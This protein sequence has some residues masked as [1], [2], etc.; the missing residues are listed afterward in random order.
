M[1][2]VIFPGNFHPVGTQRAADVM[3]DRVLT[4]SGGDTRPHPGSGGVWLIVGS[5]GGFG[6][7][8]RL[9]LGGLEGAHT[10]GLSLD[11]QPNPESNNKI[12]KLGSPG[13]HRNRAVERRLTRHGLIARSLDGDAFAPG[14]RDRVVEEIRDHFPAKLSGIVWSLAAPRATDPRT[15][16][17]VA[18][19]LKPLGK[20]A[21]IKTLR[22]PDAKKGEPA[23]VEEIELPP[24]SPEEA[25]S[26]IYVMG[27]GIVAQW[28]EHLIEADVLAEGC[29][30]LTISYRGNPMN[31]PIY[32]DG[33]IGLAKADLEL[34]TKAL[35]ARLGHEVG[36]GAFA[37]EGPAVVTEASGGIP[38]VPFYLAT[39][40]DVMGERHED[41]IDSM[42]R[43]VNEHLGPAGPKPDEEGLI[44]MDDRELGDEV[45]EAIAARFGSAKPGDA[46]DDAAFQRFMAEYA[47]TR[48]FEVPGVDYGAEFDTDEVT[49]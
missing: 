14:M 37:V 19:A 21:T 34:Q 30:L 16:E 27:G 43:L 23:R 28:V 5:S 18:S 17:T 42:I 44:R 33:L 24:G 38:G 1:G 3:F 40:L 11:A 45:R 26:T 22:A 6:S 32:R 8:A 48:G 2:N 39:L 31:A 41:P 15:G 12:R 36:G 29:T 46:F 49:S 47:R 13:Y 10:L 4:S 25:I 7:A 20:P 9:A 35:A